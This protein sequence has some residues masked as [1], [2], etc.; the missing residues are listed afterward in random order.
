MGMANMKETIHIFHTN[1]IHS[2]F[3]FWPRMQHF[4][5]QQRQHFS[6][7]GE[8]TLFIDIGDHIDRSNIYTDATLG[9]GNVALLNEA[10]YD[11]VTIGNNE[12]ITL[13]HDELKAMYEHAEFDVVVANLRASDG[14]NPAWL[15][16]YTIKTTAQGTRI[17]LIGVTAPFEAFY[18]ELK[19]EIDEPRSAVIQLVHHLKDKVDII[20]C[21]SHLGKTEDELLAQECPEIDVIFGAHTHHIFPN[22]QFVGNVLLTGGGK[23]GQY[24]GHMTLQY[25]KISGEIVEKKD[26][27]IDNGNLLPLPHEDAFSENLLVEGKQILDRPLFTAKSMLN[28]E[29]FHYS[30]LSNF[31][32][33]AILH[34][35]GADCALFNAG[36]FL[37]ELPKGEI[38]AYD[39]H[40]ILPH[41]INLCV[42]ELS[43]RELKEVLL[44]A[45]NEDWP[46]LELKGLG[47]RGNIF[48]KML[49][50]GFSLNEKRQLCIH[51]EIAEPDALY[52][53]VTLDM[54]TFGYFFPSFKYAKKHYILPEFLRHIVASYGKKYFL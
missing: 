24:T 37:K 9:K 17:G 43:A 51:G 46:L 21:L 14:N 35:T 30:R 34:K 32:A 4:I 5:K 20:L 47:F 10:N 7:Q 52:Q 22:G 29:W 6:E 11:V 8:T 33:E 1:D 15:K 49:H 45:K 50:Y 12:G 27:L 54:F 18:N 16:A 26:Y 13:A 36:I 19:W 3:G 53:L 41:P 44:Q 2:H 48:G 38:S 39:I 28:R 23:F 25:D 42:L 31:F 40:Q